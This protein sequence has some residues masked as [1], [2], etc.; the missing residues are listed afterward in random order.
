MLPAA[1]PETLGPPP[2][3]A[4][5]GRRAA[6][7]AA[8]PRQCTPTGGTARR[9]SGALATGHGHQTGPS[10]GAGHAAGGGRRAAGGG[11]LRTPRHHLIFSPPIYLFNE[12]FDLI[13]PAPPLSDALSRSHTVRKPVNAPLCLSPPPHPAHSTLSIHYQIPVMPPN[14]KTYRIPKTN[15]KSVPKPKPTPA[16]KKPIDLTDIHNSDSGGNPESDEEEVLAA[17]VLRKGI[18]SETADPLAGPT[19]LAAAI[20]SVSGALLAE[21]SYLDG[22]EEDP[23]LE[24]TV[25]T[26]DNM[27]GVTTADP[28]ALTDTIDVND[29][30]DIAILFT[31]KE[32]ASAGVKVLTFS[33]ATAS[34]ELWPANFKINA[35]SMAYLYNLLVYVGRADSTVRLDE[36][37]EALMDLFTLDYAPKRGGAFGLFALKGPTPI[38]EALLGMKNFDFDVPAGDLQIRQPGF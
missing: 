15:D 35:A 27:E 32:L 37:P 31:R 19:A 12:T 17:R 7:G 18:G 5:G 33:P 36:S 26:A 34:G 9:P 14:N 21:V 23:P 8:D 4:R 2:R 22:I 38:I 24:P 30:H 3:T 13:R 1:K 20:E 11:A 25:S 29:L 16:K 10:G 28:S 6:D